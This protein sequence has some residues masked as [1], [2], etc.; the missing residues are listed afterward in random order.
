[1]RAA[2]EDSFFKKYDGT[3]ESKARMIGANDLPDAHRLRNFLQHPKFDELRDIFDEAIQ[4]ACLGKKSTRD[5]INEA[6]L[7]W[8]KILQEEY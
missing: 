6:T 2:L 8:N 7:E 4:N 3:I 1:M 5:A